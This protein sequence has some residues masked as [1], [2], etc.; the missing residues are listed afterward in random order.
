MDALHVQ[1]M[2]VTGSTKLAS[3]QSNPPCS[4]SWIPC[5]SITDALFQA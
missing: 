4:V 3:T 2:A 5:Y 1:R